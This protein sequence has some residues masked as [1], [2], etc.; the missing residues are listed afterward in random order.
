MHNQRAVIMTRLIDASLCQ[1]FVARSKQRRMIRSK[2]FSHIIR[3]YI[4]AYRTR[5]SVVEISN[6]L[7]ITSTGESHMPANG[8]DCESL[9]I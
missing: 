2:K 6:C 9:K 1:H 8:I 3:L 5:T 7:S 4:V